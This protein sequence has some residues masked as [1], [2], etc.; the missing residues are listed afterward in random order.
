MLKGHFD[1]V[2]LSPFSSSNPLVREMF[3]LSGS[4]DH[5]LEKVLIVPARIRDP[6][7]GVAHAG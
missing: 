7:L 5:F 4:I 3:T 6:P 2:V 1:R